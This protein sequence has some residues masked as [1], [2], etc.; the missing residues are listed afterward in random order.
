MYCKQRWKIDSNLLLKIHNVFRGGNAIFLMMAQISR[1]HMSLKQLPFVVVCLEQQV[2]T[3]DSRYALRVLLPAAIYRSLAVQQIYLS[4]LCGTSVLETS[5]YII[6]DLTSYIWTSL[7]RHKDFTS[8]TW[9]SLATYELISVSNGYN[10]A[11]I[12]RLSQE[13]SSRLWFNTKPETC[14]S[15]QRKYSQSCSAVSR[16]PKTEMPIPRLDSN[17]L[18]A[19]ITTK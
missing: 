14:F 5:S 12:H 9:A 18:F 8:C 4:S 11:R 17:H 7:A 16:R 6:M 1:G 19:T 3:L 13:D 10:R 15:K 2:V